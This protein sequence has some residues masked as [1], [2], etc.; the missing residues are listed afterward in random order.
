M[1]SQS[2]R[3][4]EDNEGMRLNEGMPES[5]QEFVCGTPIL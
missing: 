3:T 1:P 2:E 4:E 5:Y